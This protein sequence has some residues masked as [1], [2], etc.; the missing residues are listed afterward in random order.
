MPI[1]NFCLI[2]DP[3]SY[4][5]SPK[6]HACFAKQ[7]SIMLEYKLKTVPAQQVACFI[8]EF[9][10]AGG[11]G[12][13]ITAPHKQ[14]ALACA[15]RF[16]ISAQ[17]AQACN[18]LY[19]NDGVICAANTD[20]AGFEQDL[21][22]HD[23]DIYSKTILILGAGGAVCGILPQ[24]LNA[25]PARVYIVNRTLLRAQNLAMQYAAEPIQ[26]MTVDEI[27][28]IKAYIIINAISV[29]VDAHDLYASVNFADAI[30]Y[31]LN[32]QPGSNFLEYA[33]KKRA[34]QL[35]NGLGMLIEQAAAAFKLWH[36]ITPQTRAVRA[37]IHAL[38]SVY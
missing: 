4:S 33:T 34:K 2:G 38:T 32:Y 18:T 27:S 28:A 19:L 8:K 7:T 21:I 35:F 6:I 30:C 26:A 23:I 14:R 13:N 15:D 3:L 10:A 16:D 24:L 5:L 17:K 25:K 1:K 20:G 12:I 11:N 29:G 37:E 9:F 22:Y 31:D 36:G